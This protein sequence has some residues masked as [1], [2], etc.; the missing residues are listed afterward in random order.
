MSLLSQ[1]ATRLLVRR[2]WSVSV[3]D[4]HR[5]PAAASLSSS[6]LLSSR[7]SLNTSAHT[8][9][10]LTPRSLSL[11]AHRCISFNVQDNDDF[12][13]RVINSDLPVLVDFHAQYVF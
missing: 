7:S 5:L 6:S 9:S 13:E 3:K 1:M 11:S 2:I 12:T 10:F 4:F 8:Q